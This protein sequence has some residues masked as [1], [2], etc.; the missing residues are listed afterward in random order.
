MDRPNI[1]LIMSDEH[2]PH[3]TGG[4]NRFVATPNID[5]IAAEGAR[6]DSAYCNSPLCVPSRFSFWSGRYVHSINAWDN[7]SP[8]PS[9]VPTIGNYLEAGGYDTYLCGRSH[10][11]GR[12]GFGK[13]LLDYLYGTKHPAL[14]PPDRSP[15]YRRVGR[16]SHVTECGRA[17]TDPH[18][19]IDRMITDFAVR[20]L[21]ERARRPAERPWLLYV[22]F[23]RPHF[24]LIC[25][26]AYFDRYYP[27]SIELPSTAGQ[28]IETQ[29]P[30]V[31]SVRRYLCDEQALP[32]ETLR[33]AL[34]AY[35]GLI[36]F[37]DELIGAIL[38]AAAR[39]DDTVVLY[40]SDHGESGGHHGMW[41]K[42]CFYEHAARVPLVMKGP[43]IEAGRVVNEHA[44]L[45]D[46]LPTLM[47]LADQGP[48][49][50]LPGTSLLPLVR[51]D[52]RG[53]EGAGRAV[54][55][56]YHAWGMGHGGYMVRKGDH[57]LNY[58]VGHEP[59]LF[60]LRADPEELNDVAGTG[61][62]AETRAD[63]IS[64]LRSIVDP[65]AADRAARENQTRSGHARYQVP[66]LYRA[67]LR[68][69][70]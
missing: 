33:T 38:E 18:T 34:A 37:T 51:A 68:Y 17:E 12:Q 39:L 26:A 59:E 36:T 35:Y 63:M 11:V 28:A 20:F 15:E 40:T 50:T 32:E 42:H 43:G 23:F 6:F 19:E 7:G 24:P 27:D 61:A 3:I 41:Q 65:D 45:V 8:F 64:E 13:R 70:R 21:T 53:W 52:G 5:R 56:E 30:V 16:N 66:P 14:V 69:Q 48:D 10:F 49:P 58:Y 44:S 2:D 62:Y 55:S 29:H 60:D 9:S 22:G 1:I 67:K 46:V 25:A 4:T 31:Q 54:F 47:D 57:K